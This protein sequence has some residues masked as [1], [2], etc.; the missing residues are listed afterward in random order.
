MACFHLANRYRRGHAVPRE[1]SVLYDDDNVHRVILG[2]GLL[3]AACQF[4]GPSNIA[5]PDAAIAIDAPLAACLSDQRYMDGAG[6][7]IRVETENQ[8]SWD[9]ARATCQ[10][11][12]ADLAVL[13]SSAK[14][15]FADD[16]APSVHTWVGL[17]AR[18]HFVWE[19][20]DGRTFV[21]TPGEDGWGDGRPDEGPPGQA[22]A[23]LR[24]DGQFDD[25]PCDQVRD[26]AC[27]CGSSL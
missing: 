15:D 23:R 27:Q 16:L 12:G 5:P 2:W 24:G 14:R 13:D 7:S 6:I 4:E 9:D 20:V 19:W 22:C 17:S 25:E 11:E 10:S 21:V 26:Y 8:A 18:E 3:T 1:H